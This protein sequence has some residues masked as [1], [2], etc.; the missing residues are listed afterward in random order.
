[1]VSLTATTTTLLAAYQGLKK[2]ISSQEV[3]TT[4][5]CE[6][7]A[8]INSSLGDELQR[9]ESELTEMVVLRR[10][11]TDSCSENA[12]LLEQVLVLGVA[13]LLAC[14]CVCVCVCVCVRRKKK[15]EEE[16][17]RKETNLLLPA[18]SHHRKSFKTKT[19]TTTTTCHS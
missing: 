11:F 5:K 9:A 18:C 7:L 17:G 12:R 2:A 1:M 13:C 8:Q 16:E 4:K 15:K 10:Q 6:Q 14:L 19:N 3:S